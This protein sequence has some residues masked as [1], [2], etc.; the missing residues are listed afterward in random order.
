MMM[1]A[2]AAGGLPVVDDQKRLADVHNPGGYFED[3]RVSQLGADSSWL[4]QHRGSGVKI[5]SHLLQAFPSY[6]EAKILFMRRPISE[7]VA[8]QNVMLGKNDGGDWDTLLRRELGQTLA[9]LEGQ[10]HLEVMEVSY[11][12]VL[13]EPREQM[14]RVRDFLQRDLDL[15]AMTA[16]VDPALYRQRK[17]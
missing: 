7:V 16:V 17:S 4:D 12:E 3:Q 8:S 9:W 5:L 15:E 1:C 14:S 11:G 10:A 6:L 2:L 13:R